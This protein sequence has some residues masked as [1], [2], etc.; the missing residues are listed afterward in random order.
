MDT[1]KPLL[2]AVLAA[3]TPLALAGIVIV[4]A[5]QLYLQFAKQIKTIS[6]RLA[7]RIARYMFILALIALLMG[8]AGWIVQIVI[9]NHPPPPP[10]TTARVIGTVYADDAQTSIPGATVVVEPDWDLP[11]RSARTDSEGN[12]SL[13]YENVN[14]LVT[15]HI[16]A[17]ADGYHTAPPQILALDP[18]S[19]HARRYDL[20]LH[21]TAVAPPPVTVPPTKPA[22]TL[23]FPVFANVHA[24][25]QPSAPPANWDVVYRAT[26]T[27]ELTLANSASDAFNQGNYPVTI[28]FLTQANAVSSSGVWKSKYPKLAAAYFLTGQPEQG[29]QVLATME[30]DIRHDIDS[31]A[32]YLGWQTTLGFVIQDL[33]EARARV[34]PQAQG[35]FDKA[36]DAVTALK[37]TAR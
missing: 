25:L 9:G 31:G 2:D 36:I 4:I 15:G 21:R 6:H 16:W 5:S 8:G 7:E 13:A 26:R 14:G 17:S 34:D 22:I 10:P 3:K 20:N 12:F 11:K 30:S 35:E 1:L 32:G 19:V 33:G 27:D 37:K 23:R 18:S 29:R 24:P 28:K